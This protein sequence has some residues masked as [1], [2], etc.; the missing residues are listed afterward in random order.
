MSFCFSVDSRRRRGLGFG[1]GLPEF[2]VLVSDGVG[3]ESARS[4]TDSET[5]GR[6]DTF[7][8][9]TAERP[10]G[11]AAAQRHQPQTQPGETLPAC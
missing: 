8:R 9:A 1:S 4:Q 11:G 3:G 7:T 6:S 2:S 10:P 5:S